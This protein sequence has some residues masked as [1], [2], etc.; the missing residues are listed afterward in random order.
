MFSV[1]QLMPHPRK[2][3]LFAAGIIWWSAYR[4]EGN[5]ITSSEIY[6][7][8]GIALYHRNCIICYSFGITRLYSLESQ[9][10]Y[11]LIVIYDT[12]LRFRSCCIE[13]N[14]Q[15]LQI[16]FFY[17]LNQTRDYNLICIVIKLWLLIQLI[18]AMLSNW[19]GIS[20]ETLYPAA[21]DAKLRYKL[22]LLWKDL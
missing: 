16:C 15:T 12:F 10:S 3:I 14:M 20:T 1:R 11:I 4:K 18:S 2:P 5:I 19:Y 7:S 13:K 22:K 6:I 9:L 21:C 8:S 17:I